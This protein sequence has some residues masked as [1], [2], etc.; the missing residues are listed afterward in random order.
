MLVAA[1]VYALLPTTVLMGKHIDKLPYDAPTGTRTLPVLVGERPAKA[2]TQAMMVAYYVGVVA[3][4]VAAGAAVAGAADAC[5]RCRRLVKTLRAFSQPKPTERT[6]GQPGLATVV[7]AARVPAH[8]SRRR[9]AHPWPARL[10]DLAR[11]PL[12]TDPAVNP[13]RDR[14]TVPCGP[15]VVDGMR[16]CV[17]DNRCFVDGRAWVMVEGDRR[18][19]SLRDLL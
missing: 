14:Q 9:P 12:R 11:R 16:R 17:S 1:T 5:S 3:L 15:L 10:G 8:P 6:A 19:Q 4:V 18:H 7:G 13:T 2:L